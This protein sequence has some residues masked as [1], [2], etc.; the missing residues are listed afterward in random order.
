[1]NHWK[2][3]NLRSLE[4]IGFLQKRRRLSRPF[5]FFC[6]PYLVVGLLIASYGKVWASQKRGKRNPEE[7]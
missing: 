2:L 4:G 3:L 1:M 7:H 6:L 5:V